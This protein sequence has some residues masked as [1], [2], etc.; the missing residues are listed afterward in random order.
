MT[1]QGGMA[2]NF[3]KKKKRGRFSLDIRE[4]S[5]NNGGETLEKVF[6]GGGWWMPCPQT[7]SGWTRL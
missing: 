4:V 7:H 6:Q 2:S 1:E 3:K 5:Y